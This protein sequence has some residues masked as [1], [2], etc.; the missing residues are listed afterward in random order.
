MSNRISVPKV[1]KSNAGFYIGQS[2]TEFVLN[3]SDEVISQ[4]E[5]PYSRLSGYYPSRDA[6]ALSLIHI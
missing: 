6:A 3:H 1:M 4:Y 2:Y 5:V